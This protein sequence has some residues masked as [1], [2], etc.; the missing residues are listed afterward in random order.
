LISSLIFSSGTSELFWETN[1][2]EFENAS[3]ERKGTARLVVLEIEL[4]L[5]V[6]RA[7]VLAYCLL[8]ADNSFILCGM[9][10]DRT[11][12]GDLWGCGEIALMTCLID[13]FW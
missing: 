12:E 5:C 13:C 7:V 6:L 10:E 8:I 11:P 3:S 9:M 1:A 4:F 2:V